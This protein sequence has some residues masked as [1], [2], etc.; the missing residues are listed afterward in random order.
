MSEQ[1]KN[2]LTGIGV[3]AESTKASYDAFIRTGFTPEQAIFLSCE[4]MKELL[5]MSTQQKKQEED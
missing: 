4:L 2:F 3:M 1:L 5:Q